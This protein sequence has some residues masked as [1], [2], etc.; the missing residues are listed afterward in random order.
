MVKEVI[1]PEG[2][3]E[4]REEVEEIIKREKAEEDKF[5]SRTENKDKFYSH[6]VLDFYEYCFGVPND[7]FKNYL[8]KIRGGIEAG[9][10]HIEKKPNKDDFTEEF[11]KTVMFCRDL[12]RG[13]EI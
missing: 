12:I 2:N 9:K 8:E 13:L 11:D 10:Y 3:L 6:S 1:G 4:E 5:K 7:E